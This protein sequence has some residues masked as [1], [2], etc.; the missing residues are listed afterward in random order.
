MWAK[1]KKKAEMKIVPEY[2]Q[3]SYYIPAGES[4]TI[5]KKELKIYIDRDWM[6]FSN[7]RNN[8]SCIW[9]VKIQNNNMNAAS[10]T[11]PC[12]LKQYMCKHVIGMQL[13]LHNLELPDRIRW[14]ENKRAKRGRP[15]QAKPALV[16]QPSPHSD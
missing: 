15:L 10:C 7:F 8:S 1:S 6:D 3:T 9:C 4:L 12:Y 5:L 13:W 2:D 14:V 16:R 11:C